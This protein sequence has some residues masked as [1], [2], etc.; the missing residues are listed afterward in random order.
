MTVTVA[1]AVA[2]AIAI[3]V[4]IVAIGIAQCTAGTTAHGRADQPVDLF[5][6][7][8]LA[9]GQNQAIAVDHQ[10]LLVPIGEGTRPAHVIRAVQRLVDL[11]QLVF[12]RLHLEC[13]DQAQGFIDARPGQGDGIGPPLPL[14]RHGDLIVGNTIEIPLMM[15]GDML[16][17]ID[18]VQ[19]LGV[20]E[21]F[22]K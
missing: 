14:D 7:G 1:F 2:A 15:L 19:F 9:T 13:A 6:G 21:I 20:K 17:D 22:G 16:D 10:P 4:V 8:D 3:V 18:G 5:G 12:G 11:R